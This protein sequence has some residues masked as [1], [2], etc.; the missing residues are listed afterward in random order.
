M[1][2]FPR[3]TCIYAD[4]VNFSKVNLQVFIAD[5]VNFG[6]VNLQ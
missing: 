5:E 1:L 2:T 3:L 6:K 4:E